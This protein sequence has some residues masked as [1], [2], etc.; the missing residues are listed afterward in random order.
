MQRSDDVRVV[1]LAGGEGKGLASLTTRKDGLCVPKQFCGWLG[2]EALVRATMR[3]ATRLVPAQRV[4][5]SLLE[6]HALHWREALGD[7]ATSQLIRQPQNRGTGMGILLPLLHIYRKSPDATVVILPS[8]H[9]VDD[10]DVFVSALERAIHCAQGTEKRAVLLGVTPDRPETDYGWVVPKSER[11][12][13]TLEVASFVEKPT[14]ARA[15][16]LMT[17]GGMWSS[18]VLVGKLPALFRLYDR[19]AHLL[20][21]VF[22]RSFQRNPDARNLESLYDIT[23]PLDFSQDLL[24]ACPELVRL[25]P[26][27]NC[28]WADLGSPA[29]VAACLRQRVGRRA[30]RLRA[31]RGFNEAELA[32]RSGLSVTTI[33][34]Y[35]AGALGGDPALTADLASG[36]GVR[37]ED[38]L[39]LDD[40]TSHVEPSLSRPLL[41]SARL[42]PHLQNV[43]PMRRPTAWHDATHP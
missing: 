25:L 30:K 32:R 26:M 16:E 42:P 9:H 24:E 22:L 20:L 3:R 29:R 41:E 1:I 18:L 35:E 38:I 28:G 21:H 2:D 33:E 39:G 12:D 6:R 37:L 31:L 43:V 40:R 5:F 8:D 4:Y 13:G 15:R 14:Q 11:D 36:L 7:V 27:P 17:R 10:E 34:R 19:A 23:P